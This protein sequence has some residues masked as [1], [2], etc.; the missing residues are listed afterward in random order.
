MRT[1]SYNYAKNGLRI[2]LLGAAIV[3]S[4][5]G[6]GEKKKTACSSCMSHSAIGSGDS[7]LLI[8]GKPVIT[9]GQF[10]NQIAEIV[11]ANPQAQSI[12][13]SIPQVKYDIFS[14]MVLQELLRTWADKNGI[15]TTES[16]KAEHALAH[17]VLEYEL[18]NKYFQEEISKT[19]SVTDADLQ[20]YYDENKL[21]NPGLITSPAGV[22]AL[23]VEFVTQAACDAFIKKAGTTAKEFKNAAAADK[24]KVKDLGLISDVTD[25]GD[26][27]DATTSEI[28]KQ[29]LAAK[30]VPS[31]INVATS[32]KKHWAVLLVSK[33]A[34]EYAPFNEVKDAIENALKNEKMAEAYAQKTDELKATYNVEVKE[35]YFKD[36]LQPLE[37]LLEDEIN[38][39]GAE[40]EVETA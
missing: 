18:A 27:M 14:S 39:D 15:T 32:G 1:V 13:E 34:A 22:N 23:G 3:F 36:A 30:A 7:L 38:E 12:I 31:V 21:S 2:F 9:V 20:K 26:Q 10:E 11:K 17:Q 33:K 4:G 35:E 25:L 6:W 28:K 40:L 37:G 5:C 29:V 24:V 8:G 16:Y 19:I